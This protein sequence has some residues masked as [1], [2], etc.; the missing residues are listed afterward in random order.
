MILA[1]RPCERYISLIWPVSG[2]GWVP[3]RVLEKEK[4]IL[5]GEMRAKPL[6]PW[7]Q[8]YV[9]NSLLSAGRPSSIPRRLSLMIMN[10][11]KIHS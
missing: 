5:F 3:L 11:R 2:I 9:A 8:K 10:A 6:D 4:L 7:N 1:N